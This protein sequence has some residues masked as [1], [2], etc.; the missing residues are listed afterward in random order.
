[1]ADRAGP[2]GSVR[3]ARVARLG[4]RP[5][6]LHDLWAEWK[7]GSAGFKAASSFTSHERGKVKS[8]FSMRKPFWDK[9]DE[10][11]RAG[12]TAQVACDTIYRA[13][14]ENLPVTQI[15]RRMKE[16]R[17]ANSWPPSLNTWVA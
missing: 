13:Y 2:G 5:K 3:P 15:L 11:V 4:Q 7:F 1:V 8:L 12:M 17:R 16:D 9:C 14:G 10:L 6:T